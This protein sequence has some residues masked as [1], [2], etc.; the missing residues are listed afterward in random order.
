V[1]D[2]PAPAAAVAVRAFASSK[3]GFSVSGRVSLLP[4]TARLTVSTPAEMNTSPSPARIA[5]IAILVV[6]NDDEQYRV[7]VAPGSW[8]YPSRTAT[9]R[10]RLNPDSPPGCPQ[11][12]RRSSMASGSSCGTWSS[13]AR[14]TVAARSSGRMS[15]RLP[16]KAR[17]M[18]E[19]AAATMTAS[20][21]PLTVDSAGSAPIG[22]RAQIGGA[23]CAPQTSM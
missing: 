7:I 17:P 2:G 6:C 5:C 10:A 14:T 20:A 3:T 15:R 11:P 8:S 18:G 13:A 4:L 21:M 9:T 22:P 23:A 12:S 16:L 19:R 1:P